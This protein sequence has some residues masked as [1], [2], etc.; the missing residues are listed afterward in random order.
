MRTKIIFSSLL[1]ALIFGV[2]TTRLNAQK[3]HTRKEKLYLIETY[4]GVQITGK[5]ISNNQEKLVLLNKVKGEIAI[6]TYQIKSKREL[7]R[8][9]LSKDGEYIAKPLFPSR[10]FI[11]TNAFPVGKG[12]KNFKMNL[13]GPDLQFGVNDHLDVSLMTTWSVTP[14]ILNVKYSNAIGDWASIA[15]GVM[16]L[17]GSWM[18]LNTYGAMA[19]GM[20]TLGNARR[21]VNVGLNYAWVNNFNFFL[22]E[23]IPVKGT[24]VSLGGMYRISRKTALV[25]DSYILTGIEKDNRPGGFVLSG[26]RIDFKKSAFQFGFLGSLVE[27][28]IYPAAIPLAEYMIKF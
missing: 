25:F 28:W 1:I 21:N 27:G 2:T 16:G 24:L 4:D 26:I 5:I 15:G 11:A 9:E 12:E 6:P 23:P 14:I 3:K 22:G 13:L 20:L 8:D 18:D 17:T 10:Y 7:K 19:Y